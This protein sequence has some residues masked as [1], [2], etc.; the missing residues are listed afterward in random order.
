[1]SLRKSPRLT[2][3][4]L[5][6]ARANSRRSTGPRQAASKQ[7]SK[8]NALKHGGYVS[9]ANQRQ[10]LRALGEDP[11]QFEALRAELRSAFDAGDAL[12]EQ[13]V[14]D[15]AW[16]YWRRERLERMQTGLKRRAL[17]AIKERQHRRR[18]EMADATFDASRHEMLLC[19][20][21]APADPAVML[22][23]TL[24]YLELVRAEVGEGVYAQRQGDVL[25]EHY[26]DPKG[27]RLMLIFRLIGLFVEAK[28]IASKGPGEDCRP[29]VREALGMTDPPGERDRQ[30]L[31]KLL[32][33]E[34]ASVEE[35]LEYE[36]RQNQERAAI[37]REACLA[38]EGKTWEMLLRQESG[39]DRAIDRKVKILLQ[40]RKDAI[41]GADMQDCATPDCLDEPAPSTWVAPTSLSMSATQSA[42]SSAIQGADIQGN[43]CATPAATPRSAHN[44]PPQNAASANKKIK[45]RSGNVDENKRPEL[46]ETHSAEVLV[47][48][49][50]PPSVGG[51]DMAFQAGGTQRQ[52]AS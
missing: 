27:W 24:S 8:F 30:E 32:A 13:Q 9:A 51:A 11:E 20:L 31:L 12:S 6:A 10:A 39:L 14:E 46:R 4:L 35:E 50:C 52:N 23:R 47:G 48:D 28:I 49:C 3:E 29:Y 16:L 40:L 22:R 25:A 41:Q 45:E 1:M 15:L 2:T 36:E 19:T 42:D 33:E 43:V 21:P 17:E 44:A 5:E 38:P 37:E 34:I 18:R 26:A 7:N